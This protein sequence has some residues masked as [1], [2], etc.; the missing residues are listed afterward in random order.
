MDTHQ[1]MNTQLSHAESEA[2]SALHHLESPLAPH[3]LPGRKALI[4]LAICM[5]LQMTSYVMILPLFARRFSE[6]G[7]GVESLGESAMAYALAATLAAPFMG[8][9]A[10]RF[11]RRLIVL[12]SLGIYI[13]AFTGYLFASSTWMLILLRGLA[14]AFTA[15]LIPAV[16]GSVADLAP[17]DRKAQW[18]GIVNGGASIGWIVGP[19]VGGALYDH[20]GYNVA[21]VISILLAVAAFTGATIWVPETHK[22]TRRSDGKIRRTGTGSGF[23]RVKT[24]LLS[25]RSSLPNSLSTFSLLLWISFAIMFAWA[26]I[27]PRF[28]FYAYDDLGWTS[29]KLGLVMST[30]GVSMTLGEFGLSR[31]SDRLGRKSIILL[32]LA[33]FSAQFIGLAFFKNY[34]LI[35][36]AFLVAGLGNALYD[37]ALSAAILEIGSSDHRAGLLGIKSTAGSLGNILGPGLVVLFTSWLDAS[38]IFLISAGVV[39]LTALAVFASR[40]ARQPLTYLSANQPEL[41]PLDKGEI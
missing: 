6:L 21:L 5:A 14:G 41:K 16:T 19:I 8:A 1:L 22:L 26:F 24:S 31:L 20:W 13:L 10:D 38:G 18:I 35:A 3:E 32:G 27:E 4:I 40:L 36:A 34:M 23:K 28:M 33:L 7:A 30:Y 25:I 12:G 15:G 2:H 29:S 11:G 9:L 37:P 17:G 39:L